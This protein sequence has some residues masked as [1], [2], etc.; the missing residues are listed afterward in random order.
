MFPPAQTFLRA[1]AEHCQDIH[2][3]N[4]LLL[5][6]SREGALLY[7]AEI[8]DGWHRLLDLVEFFPSLVCVA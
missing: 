5:L 1:L 4:T 3:T 8:R 2:D 7:D 6:S